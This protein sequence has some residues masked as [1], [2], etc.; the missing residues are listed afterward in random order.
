MTET[1][2]AIISRWFDAPVEL[3]WRAFTDPDQLASWYGPDGVEVVR[4]SVSVEARPG[5]AWSL[6]MVMG[7]RTMP[8]SGTVTE[9][10][11]PHR[12][13]VTDQMPDGTT[14]TMTV[15]LV[16]ENGGTRLQLRQGPFP[17]EGAAGASGAWEQAM[18]KL[19]TSLAGH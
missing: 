14:V 11:E 6:T 7:D 13:V 19:A 5:G 10:E 18:D 2:D 12:L 3:V 9:V 17:S 8:L 1:R 16:E 4:E 15:E